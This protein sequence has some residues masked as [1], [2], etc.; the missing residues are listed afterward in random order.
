MADLPSPFDQRR[1][2]R[3]IASEGKLSRKRRTSLYVTQPAVSLQ[4]QEIWRSS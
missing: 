1:I 2:L 3:S 4:I